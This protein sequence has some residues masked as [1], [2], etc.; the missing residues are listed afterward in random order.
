MKWKGLIT[1]GLV[2]SSFILAAFY[3]SINVK[4][5]ES[6]ILNAVMNYLE[7]LHFKPKTID[8]TFSEQAFE[9]FLTQVDAGKRFLTQEEIDQLAIHREAIDDQV[10]MRTFPFFEAAYEVIEAS[11]LRA[12]RIFNEV[13][14]SEFDINADGTIELDAQK[15]EFA[16]DEAALKENWKKYIQ[17]D[18]ITKVEDLIKEQEDDDDIDEPKSVEELEE[19]A[20]AEIKENYEEYFERLSKDRR[21]DFFEIYIN[22][23]T[24]LFDP[25]SDYYNP[26]EKQD[27]D[28]RMGGKLEGI[29]ARLQTDGEYT[30]VVSIVPGGPAWKQGELEVGDVI[31][32]VTQKGEE[33]FDIKG[34]RIDDVVQQIRGDKGTI[35]ILEIKKSSGNVVDVEIERDEVILDEGF[36]RSLTLDIPGVIENVG[37]IKLPKFYSEFEGNDGNSCAI[38]VAKELDK[39]TALNVNGVILDLR[40]NG[41][42]SLRDVVDMTGLFFEDGPVVQV[43]PRSKDAYVYGDENADVSYDGPLIVMVNQFSAS[44]S[45]ILAAALQDYKRAVIVGSTSTFGKGTV[46][47]FVDLDRAYRDQDAMKPLGQLKITMQKFYRVDG[48]S[49]QLKGVEPDIVF[50]DNYYYIDIGEKDYENAM[51]WSE[52]EPVEYEQDVYVV[53]DVNTLKARSEKRMDNH[54]SFQLMLENASRLKKNK[55]ITQYPLSLPAYTSYVDTR[56]EE[57]RK[58][59]NLY[60]NDIEE[61]LV[62]NLAVDTSYINFDESRIARNEDWLDRVQTDFY[63]EETLMILKDMIELNQDNLSMNKLD[64]KEK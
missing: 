36:A 59:E 3:P 39:L 22:S 33:S 54:E 62:S 38:D 8:N 27:F 14:E 30:K 23:I 45:E 32:S 49:T 41:G 1:L 26:K 29:G 50:P 35:V 48:G 63:L 19:E 31:L 53:N 18:I 6:L 16:A 24:H 25:H 57:A 34:L 28:I 21:S 61:L 46:Q 7:V 4:Q 12:E 60:D 10:K 52:I 40:N 13:I 2:L 47:R 11:R 9:E 37:Y 5:K 44:A 42:G 56:T 64:K 17:F 51:E 43:K 20:I 55:E 58:Y 15:R